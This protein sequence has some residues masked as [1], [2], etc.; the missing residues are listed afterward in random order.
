MEAT[1]TNKEEILALAEHAMRYTSL[2]INQSDSW[3]TEEEGQENSM[4]SY[5]KKERKQVNM[6]NNIPH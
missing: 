4:R 6:R 2:L 5:L 3:L 1:K